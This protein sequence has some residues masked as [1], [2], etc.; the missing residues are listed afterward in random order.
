M[1][2]K[3][4]TVDSVRL[5]ILKTNPLTLRIEAAGSVPTSGYKDAELAAWIYIQPPADGIY[6]FDFIARPP[7]GHVTQIVSPIE[8]VEHWQPFPKGLK[9]VRIIS[10]SNEK[11]AMLSSASEVET[12]ILPAGVMPWPGI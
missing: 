3:V 2:V 5:T 8:A 7:S 4:Q 12:T 9:G 1:F 10:S 11:T 6:S